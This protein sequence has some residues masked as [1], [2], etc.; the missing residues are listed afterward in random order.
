MSFI[1]VI[2]WVCSLTK[3]VLVEKDFLAFHIQHRT[4]YLFMCMHL[5]NYK[6]V[7]THGFLHFKLELK[8]RIMLSVNRRM[9]T[10][11]NFQVYTTI[12]WGAYIWKLEDSKCNHQNMSGRVK[13]I[14]R[15]FEE[16]FYL[17]RSFMKNNNTEHNNWFQVKNNFI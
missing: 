5:K 8:W 17:K 6:P 4:V 1:R 11:I 9:Q 7:Q 16:S 14:T 12:I 10:I 15:S 2:I 13:K 3:H